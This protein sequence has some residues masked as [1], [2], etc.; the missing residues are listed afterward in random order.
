MDILPAFVF[1]ESVG[2]CHG[3]SSLRRYIKASNILL[4]KKLWVIADFDCAG[5]VDDDAVGGT[6][7]PPE[8]RKRSSLNKSPRLSHKGDV[9]SLGVMLLDILSGFTFWVS[10]ES[11][12]DYDKYELPF[13]IAILSQNF[14][15]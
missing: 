7:T 1:L 9:F 4:W 12:R 13:V 6:Y 10:I 2:I 11:Y 3:F 14:R 5:F 8:Y 15:P